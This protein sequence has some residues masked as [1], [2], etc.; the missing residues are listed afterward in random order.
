MSVKGLG[1][2]KKP[3]LYLDDFCP[4]ID[5]DI[6]HN[7]VSYGLSACRWIKR[8]VSAGVHP[9]WSEKE[10]STHIIKNTF[11]SH[12]KELFEMIDVRDT[13]KKLKFTSLVT[14]GLHP[15]WSCYLRVNRVKENTGIAN[16]SVSAD[17][18]WTDNV[19]HFP[20]LIKLIE[21][22]PMTEIGRV[23][24][25]ITEPNNETVPHF[26]DSPFSTPR[27]NDDFIYFST[28]IDSSKKI[29]VMDPDTLEKYYP[30]QDKKFLWFNE[31]D[32]HGTDPT[33]RLT[34]SVRIEGKFVPGIKEKIIN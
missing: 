6:L 26:D 32:Y 22:L 16:K 7:E 5:W 28:I 17:C 3:F 21:Q 12:Q 25:F 30:E 2:H 9:N 1:I 8:F 34:F 23:M 24:F 11:T 29:Y 13:E 31:M 19:Q 4:S 10:I 18:E 33:D 27:P 20:S 15:F 14:K